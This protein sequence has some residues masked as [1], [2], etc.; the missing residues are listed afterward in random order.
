L[1]RKVPLNEDAKAGKKGGG[2]KWL[3]PE[4][5]DKDGT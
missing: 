4:I 1:N 5:K 3:R 2:A